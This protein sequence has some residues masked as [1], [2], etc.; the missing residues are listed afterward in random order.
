MKAAAVLLLLNLLK[1]IISASSRAHAAID[2]IYDEMQFDQVPV[3]NSDQDQVTTQL[4]PDAPCNFKKIP[5][6]LWVQ[7]ASFIEEPYAFSLSCKLFWKVYAAMSIH[8]VFNRRLIVPDDFNL[9]PCIDSSL[10]VPSLIKAFGNRDQKINIEFL[11][12]NLE[13]ALYSPAIRAAFDFHMW[14]QV[15]QVPFFKELT[16]TILMDSF[17]EIR[18]P[19]SSEIESHRR[20]LLYILASLPK[21]SEIIQNFF[22]EYPVKFVKTSTE[23]CFQK[24]VNPVSDRLALIPI[25]E[26]LLFLFSFDERLIENLVRIYFQT[27]NNLALKTLLNI[28]IPEEF[29]ELG[30]VYIGCV[31]VDQIIYFSEKYL[32]NFDSQMIE[33]VS[34][35]DRA[36]SLHI[37]PLLSSLSDKYNPVPLN[38]FEIFH[39][40]VLKSFWD[41]LNDF[42]DFDFSYDKNDSEFLSFLI[43]RDPNQANPLL[44]QVPKLSSHR[45]F[46]LNPKYQGRHFGKFT[47]LKSA[48]IELKRTI[49]NPEITRAHI[50][51]IQDNQERL[52]NL[53]IADSADRISNYFTMNLI[54]F[55]RKRYKEHPSFNIAL[56]ALD[57]YFETRLQKK[58][59][60][61]EIDPETVL[62]TMLIDL[63]LLPEKTEEYFELAHGLPTFTKALLAGGQEEED[64]LAVPEAALTQNFD[65]FEMLSRTIALNR[66]IH[67]GV[68]VNYRLVLQW[69]EQFGMKLAGRIIPIHE[70]RT[71]LKGVA[72]QTIRSTKDKKLRFDLDNQNRDD[73]FSMTY[74]YALIILVTQCK[75]IPAAVLK[76]V[77]N[78][79]PG[80]NIDQSV[81]FNNLLKSACNYYRQHSQ[82]FSH[83]SFVATNSRSERFLI[84]FIRHF[85]KISNLRNADF[86]EIIDRFFAFINLDPYDDVL[87]R[88][89]FTYFT[90]MAAF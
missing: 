31:T 84:D 44:S 38:I 6:V 74:R 22:F 54:G 28:K 34:E 23:N 46:L 60:N 58:S 2:R 43:E 80:A 35:F 32:N 53:L 30:R 27:G 85:I 19:E 88:D 36:N 73:P 49:N 39:V 42:E 25:K 69:F 72:F 82:F 5:E 52:F 86:N 48:R 1:P 47:N 81:G 18:R 16:E 9:F 76:R 71:L 75:G 13:L 7:I 45:A 20:T 11:A 15:R 17:D 62:K 12:K 4:N 41:V 3:I 87:L 8:R 21:S 50:L 64:T 29:K 57:V 33:I 68:F 59:E 37:S 89:H 77:K 40:A 51:Y 67:D 63:K 26:K 56:T 55:E 61:P 10:S 78:L 14:K 24:L 66:V 70:L 90:L 83:F 65:E 79:F